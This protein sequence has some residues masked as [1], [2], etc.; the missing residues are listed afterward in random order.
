MRFDK[1]SSQNWYITQKQV[2]LH[3]FKHNFLPDLGS[4]TLLQNICKVFV[5]I[6]VHDFS[7]LM[8]VLLFL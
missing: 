8:T 5:R 6:P 2:T 4:D 7:I 3:I 1:R